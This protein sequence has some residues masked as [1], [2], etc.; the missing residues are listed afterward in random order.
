MSRTHD[1]HVD[2]TTEVD[3]VASGATCPDACGE[4]AENFIQRSPMIATLAV[5]GLGLGVG[6]IIGS[7]LADS[8]PPS[9]RQQAEAL[10]R[11]VLDSLSDVLPDSVRRHLG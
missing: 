8:A 11:R 7:L 6:A 5:F 3:Q 9:R 2:Y 1:S 10:G 4:W